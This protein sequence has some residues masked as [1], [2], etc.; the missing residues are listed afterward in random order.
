M[1]STTRTDFDLNSQM[2][3]PTKTLRVKGKRKQIL[4]INSQTKVSFK[5]FIL[6][7][8]LKFEANSK[9]RKEFREGER[10]IRI[11]YLKI[12]IIE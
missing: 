7:Y 11:T 12:R 5:N 8:I 1:K 3:Y 4:S 6:Y 10:E 2:P 9:K